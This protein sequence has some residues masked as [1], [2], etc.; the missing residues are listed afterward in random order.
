MLAIGL[1]FLLVAINLGLLP[2]STFVMYAWLILVVSVLIAIACLVV[3]YLLAS[4]LTGLR[5]F[6]TRREADAEVFR[7]AIAERA[8]TYRRDSNS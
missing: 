4:V 6:R 8:K 1:G 5:Q 3:F 2:V 7:A